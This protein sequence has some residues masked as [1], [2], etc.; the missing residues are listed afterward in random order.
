MTYQKKYQDLFAIKDSELGHTDTVKM[1][2]DTG[3]HQPIKLGPYRTP[4]QNR[5]VIEKAVD[6]MLD[7]S[8]I[9]R[10]K[11]PW[12]FPIVKVEKKDWSKRLCVEFRKSNQITKSNSYPLP[13]IDDI[14]AL[15]GNI[16]FFFRFKI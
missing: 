4:I 5:A 11:S 12:S 3:E 10:S 7:A 9:R 13:L 14:L 16:S 2:I 15:L 6:E 8:V 1:R